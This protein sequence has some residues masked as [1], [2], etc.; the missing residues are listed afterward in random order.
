MPD[1]TK[2]PQYGARYK[3][4]H[5]MK[6]DLTDKTQY[7]SYINTEGHYKVFQQNKRLNYKVT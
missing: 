4:K 3:M 6:T 5:Q 2:C 7:M 1:E